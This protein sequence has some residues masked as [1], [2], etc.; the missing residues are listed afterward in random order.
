MS[1]HVPEIT[2]AEWEEKVSRAAVPVVVDFFSTECPP[3]EA[4]APRLEQVAGQYAG[5]VQVYKMFRQGNREKALELGVLGS[6]TLVFFQGGE[7]VG[8]RMTGGAIRPAD[9]RRQL[10]QLLAAAPGTGRTSP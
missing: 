5:R 8:G 10:D 6:P 3:C 9:L 2:A 4:L 1:Q 7:E